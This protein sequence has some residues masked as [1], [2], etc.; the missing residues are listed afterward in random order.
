MVR[1]VRHRRPPRPAAGESKETLRLYQR[2]KKPE[3]NVVRCQK[4]RAR[5]E[6]GYS[7]SQNTKASDAGHASSSFTFR[8]WVER[9]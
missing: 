9:E 1:V 3:P 8:S 6:F 2:R 5:L 4:Q 7:V